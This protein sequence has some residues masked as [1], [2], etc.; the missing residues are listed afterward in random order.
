MRVIDVDSHYLEPPGWLEQVDPALAKEIPASDATDRVVRGVVGDLLDVVP[1]S[2]LPENPLALLGPSGRRLFEAM[3]EMNEDEA[4]TAA[5]GPKSSYDADAR[6]AFCDEHGI[7]VQFLNSTLGTGPFASAMK[8]D[9][10]DLARRALHAFN[11]WSGETLAGHTDRLIPIALVDVSDVDWAIAEITRM[12]AKGSRAF[13]VRAEPASETKSLAHPDFD[14]L[15]DAAE[16]LGMALV[17]H[18]VGGRADLKRGWFFNG[19]DPSHFAILHLVNAPIVPQIALAALLIEGVLE[20]HPGLAIIV[21]EM[22]ISWLP[23]FL[24]TI[25]SLAGGPYGQLFGLA[26]Q[27]YKLPLKPSEYMR[28]QVRVSP[29]VS[30]DPL[31]P[32]IDLVPEEMLVFSSDVP[33][34]EGRDDA[35]QLFEE[36]FEGLSDASR[37]QF[38]GESIGGLMDL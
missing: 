25:D 35:V 14:R 34:Q 6:I 23:H 19:G 2:Q 7:D 8:I 33:H 5:Q 9:R 37:V 17:F 1:A 3:M 10:P 32:T 22:G 16:D 13:Q 20:R 31:Q 11:T 26:P 27:D 18:L 30:A 21:Q 29:L 38:F 36:Q 28:R 15:W 4:A 12:R 24:S